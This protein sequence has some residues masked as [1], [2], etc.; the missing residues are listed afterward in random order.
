MLMLVAQNHWGI[1]TPANQVQSNVN[2]AQRGEPYGVK[3]A[4]VD[5]N[6]PVAA[7]EAL[8]AAM[9][10][11]R[12]ERKPF[13]LQ[14]NVSRLY[15]HSSSSGAQRLAE[16]DC[17]VEFEARLLKENL[18]TQAEIDAVGKK[19]Q[20]LLS[21]ALTRVI[22][23]PMPDKSNVMEHVFM[24]QAMCRSTQT[25]V[26]RRNPWQILHKRSG[27]RCIMAKRI[28]ASRIFW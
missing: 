27:W 11:V 9:D 22:A 12:H 3:T 5:G 17:L 15:G 25:S 10:F 23:E 18:M 14:G 16:P 7:Y 26:G 2:L 13:C 20:T 19:W 28:S 21:E 4:V 6:D 8:A 1:S 24:C